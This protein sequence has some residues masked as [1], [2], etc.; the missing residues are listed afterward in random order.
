MSEFVG[1][2]LMPFFDPILS[3][4]SL[5][6]CNAAAPVN[7]PPHATSVRVPHAANRVSSSDGVG[8]V[9]IDEQECRRLSTFIQAC[10]CVCVCVHC[11][12]VVSGVTGVGGVGCVCVH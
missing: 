10:V 2:P 4:A 9:A 5:C 12:T 6:F 3:L 11:T 1:V 8:V 7:K